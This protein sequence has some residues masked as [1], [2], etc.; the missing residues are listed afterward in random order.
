LLHFRAATR[1]LGG[2]ANTY[3]AVRISG[4]GSWSTRSLMGAVCTRPF[5][6]SHRGATGHHVLVLEQPARRNAKAFRDSRYVVDRYV[7]LATFDRT[8]VGPVQATSVRQFFLRQSKLMPQGSQA[9][10]E[11]CSQLGGVSRGHILGAA[12]LEFSGPNS[13]TDVDYESTDYK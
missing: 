9:S 12:T 10:S 8:N 13:P 7:A 11:R 1:P 6:T 2:K 3:P 5:E 4:A